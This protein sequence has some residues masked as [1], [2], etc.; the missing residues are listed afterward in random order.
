MTIEEKAKAYD[1]AFEKAKGL[2]AKGAPDSLHLEEMFPVLKDNN[3]EKIRDEIILYIGAKN[4][5]SLNTHNRWLNWLEKQG[6]QKPADKVEPKFHKGGAQASA[7]SEEDKEIIGGLNNCLDELEKEHGWNYVY[8]NDKSVEL[9]K[10]R[11]WLK[12]LR[13]R[14]LL[15]K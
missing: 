7:W 9:G 14:V 3:D 4:D 1:K 2:Y 8:I 15:M 5:I 10:I 13:P 11:N 12:S 6:E